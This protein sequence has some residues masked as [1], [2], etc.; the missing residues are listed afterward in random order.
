MLRSSGFLF[1]ALAGALALAGCGDDDDGPPVPLDGAGSGGGNAGGAAGAPNA[2]AAGS[3]S[4]GAA[5]AGAAGSAG[6]AGAAGGPAADVLAQLTAVEGLTVREVP[7]V[8]ASQRW[9][10]LEMRQPV[11]HENP[12]AGSFD[13]HMVLLHRDPG[14]LVDMLT[15]G[16]SFQGQ[17]PSG[18]GADTG[19]TSA[20]GGNILYVE[21]RFFGTS[22]PDPEADPPWQYLTVRQAAADHHHI[23][24][25]L[26]PL[27]PGRWV[28]EGASKGG[29]TALYHHRFYPNDVD[30]VIA[31]V[32]PNSL[33]TDD[34]RYVAFLDQVGDAACR[35]RIVDVQRAALSRRAEVGPLL[36][37][38]LGELGYDYESLGGFDVAYEHAVQEYR[39]AFWQYGSPDD[40]DTLPDPAAVAAAIAAAFEDVLKGFSDFTLGRFAPYYYQAAVELGQY[41]PL[42]GGIAD[43]LE[44]P[45]TYRVTNYPP[46]GVPKAF[47]PD[48]MPDVATWLATEAKHVILT[49]GELDPW[50]AGALDP[51][52]S[53]EVK[54]FVAPGGNHGSFFDQLTEADRQ[55]AYR[56]LGAWLGMTP[57]KASPKA[58]RRAPAVPWQRRWLEERGL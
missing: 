28:T 5:G 4:A 22:K 1:F 16:Y 48:A 14:A 38:P 43:L 49:Y 37:G 46:L 18:D 54:R 52:A 8:D 39:F 23:I 42:E 31:Y 44:H 32:A 24:E 40:C 58:R 55:Q 47:D 29:M 56:D 33:G 11:D 41:G 51:G 15:F 21:H 35:Q 17:K 50:T 20:F 12:A 13:Q 30:A 2:G 6:G 10:V 45:G 36:E 7:A 57:P 34:Q 19:V 53:T 27:Y 9:F 25:A 26:K 3:P